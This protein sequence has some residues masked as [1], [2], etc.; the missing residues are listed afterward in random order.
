MVHA[1]L[2]RTVKL[3]KKSARC[4]KKLFF[5]EMKKE[6]FR[7][8]RPQLFDSCRQRSHCLRGG[9][10]QSASWSVS[11]SLRGPPR[12][13]GMGVWE[14]AWRW[15]S[16]RRFG[17]YKSAAWSVWTSPAAILRKAKNTKCLNY[18]CF[19][20]CDFP[21]MMYSH[22]AQWTLCDFQQNLNAVRWKWSCHWYL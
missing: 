2:M 16:P 10:G 19:F 18:H 17:S 13:S 3:S 7:T 12:R 15:T 4:V 22:L 9:R 6:R 21:E 5:L 20:I 14:I 1:N 8:H 11:F